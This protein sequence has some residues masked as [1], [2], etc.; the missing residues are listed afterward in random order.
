MGWKCGLTQ[1]EVRN[2]QGRAEG[3]ITFRRKNKVTTGSLQNRGQ[4]ANQGHTQQKVS[5]GKPESGASQD[6]SGNHHRE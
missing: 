3:R 6:Q 4:E 1:A 5:R 2:Q